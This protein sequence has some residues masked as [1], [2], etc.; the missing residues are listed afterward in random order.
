MDF[1]LEQYESAKEQYK[2]DAFMSPCINTGWAK[3]T[4]YYGLT[5]RTPVY[6]TALVLCPQ[7]KWSYFTENWPAAWVDEAQETVL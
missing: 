4:K 6:L 2:D 5:D 3:L 7:W 1:L